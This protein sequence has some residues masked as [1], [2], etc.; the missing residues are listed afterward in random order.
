[1]ARSLADRLGVFVIAIEYSLAP[2]HPFPDAL[3]D[4]YS[5]LA[6]MNDG[7][8]DWLNGQGQFSHLP[9]IALSFTFIGGVSAGANLAIQSKLLWLSRG[10][11]QA[12]FE[13]VSDHHSHPLVSRMRFAGEILLSPD[14]M[15]SP[16]TEQYMVAEYILVGSTNTVLRQMYLANQTLSHPLVSLVNNPQLVGRALLTPLFFSVRPGLF[17]QCIQTFHDNL[18]Q[19]GFLSSLT[20]LHSLPHSDYMIREK[21]RLTFLKAAKDHLETIL[22]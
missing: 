2:E 10:E 3:E 6:F 16:D 14:L 7:E 12:K 13:G 5:V 18:N 1:M 17:H 20:T 22:E 21:S 8:A 4:C 9:P 15:R 19:A 11:G